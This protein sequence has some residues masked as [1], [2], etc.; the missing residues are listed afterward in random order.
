MFEAEEMEGCHSCKYGEKFDTEKEPCKYCYG[1][2]LY[3]KKETNMSDLKIKQSDASVEMFNKG[4]NKKA[5]IDVY[6]YLARHDYEKMILNFENGASMT[7][8]IHEPA[9]RINLSDIEEGD[10][11]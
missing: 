8:E 3:T 2:S 1:L 7:V 4:D 5:F 6:N 9:I 10:K 11:E